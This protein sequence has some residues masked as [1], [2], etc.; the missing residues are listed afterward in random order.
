MR[1]EEEEHGANAHEAGAA[2]LPLPVREL[3]KG[4]A[5]IMKTLAYRV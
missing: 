4:V 2:E 5:Q 1:D 3:M